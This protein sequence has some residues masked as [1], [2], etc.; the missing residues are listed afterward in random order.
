MKRH[1]GALS[2]HA[3]TALRS[4]FANYHEESGLRLARQRR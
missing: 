2:F 1:A 3:G 4:P